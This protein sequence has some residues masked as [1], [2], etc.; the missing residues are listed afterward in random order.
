[1][2][3]ILFLTIYIL[4]T[5]TSVA[6]I[7]TQEQVYDQLLEYQERYSIERLKVKIDTSDFTPEL[8]Y[9][10]LWIYVDNPDIVYNQAKIESGWFTHPRFT[11]YNNCLGMK[12]AKTRDHLQSGIWKKHATYTHWSDCIKDYVLWQQYWK[13]RGKQ[14]DDYY[15]FLEDLPYATATHYIKTLKSMEG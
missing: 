14:M 9:Q 10:A 6:P 4:S 2:R 8:L 12:P 15:Q 3:W 1:M 13:N 7:I 5:Q 11:V